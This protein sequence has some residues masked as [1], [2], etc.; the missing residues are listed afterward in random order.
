MFRNPFRHR[1]RES[2]E[3]GK[4]QHA[5][6]WLRREDAGVGGGTSSLFWSHHDAPPAPQRSCI[7]GH[8]IAP[9]ETHCLYGHPVG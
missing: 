7:Q 9:G 8:E 1:Q 6:G 3:P 2:H 5:A 4:D